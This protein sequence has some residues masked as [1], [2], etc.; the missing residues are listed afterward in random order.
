LRRYAAVTCGWNLSTR[1]ER[2]MESLLW[3]CLLL[4]LGVALIV[5]ELFVPS[6]GLLSVM[7]VVAVVA[8]I[9]V[10]FADSLVTGT[11]TLLFA[12][13]VVPVVV[14][15]AIKWW[16]HTPIG[17]LVLIKRPTSE[18]EVLPDTEPYQVRER[19]VGKFG[20]AKS[21]LLLSGDVLIEGRVY[22]AVSNG[23][24]ISAGQPV[25]VVDMNMRRIV[26]RP[27]TEAEITAQREQSDVLATP[28]DHLGIEPFDDPLA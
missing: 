9:V 17:K 10:A 5:L 2:T 26:V 28:L 13:V 19:M 7:A 27:M 8:S 15:G 25:K 12:T 11:L 16:P 6:G 1:A 18:D 24:P 4:M 21:E 14:A 23:M 3:P 22:D 20:V